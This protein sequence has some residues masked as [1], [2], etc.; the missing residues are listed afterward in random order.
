M[1]SIRLVRRL[2][3]EPQRAAVAVRGWLAVDGRGDAKSARGAAVEIALIVGNAG[4]NA[5]RAQEGV[6]KLSGNLK[7]IHTDHY[8]TEHRYLL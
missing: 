6:V 4:G 2:H 5:Q 1:E 7:V 3:G 8:M